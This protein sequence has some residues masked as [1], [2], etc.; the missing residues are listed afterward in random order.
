MKH[1][2]LKDVAVFEKLHLDI[3]SRYQL[4]HD[5]ISEVNDYSELKRGIE[6]NLP[7]LI[8]SLREDR[9]G[10]KYEPITFGLECLSDM[11]NL[12]LKYESKKG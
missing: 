9:G 8:T 2:D 5:L 11:E 6:I 12:V 3:K 7:K 10:N 1:E 4:I